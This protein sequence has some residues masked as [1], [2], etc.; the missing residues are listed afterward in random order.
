MRGADKWHGLPFYRSA[1]EEEAKWLL[2]S[3]SARHAESTTVGAR[4]H[5]R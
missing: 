1:P 5:Y 4:T 2:N 3:V